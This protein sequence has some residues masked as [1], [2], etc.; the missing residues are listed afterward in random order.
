MFVD[1]VRITVR[2]GKGGNGCISFRREKYVPRGGPNGGNGGN[3][4][5]V[6][7]FSDPNANT[8]LTFRYRKN[9]EAARGRHGQGSLKD[10]KSGHDLRIA[11]PVGTMVFADD[12]EHLLGDLQSPAQEL[13]VARGGRGGRG[14]ACF[15]TST[16][17]APRIAEPGGEGEERHLLLELKLLADVGLVGFPNAG[18]SSLLSRFSAARPKIADYPFTTLTPHLGLV[19]V[20]E[21]K[22]FVMADIPGIIEHAHEGAGLGLRFLK[23]VERTRL[24]LFVIDCS[25]EASREP[26]EAFRILREELRQFNTEMPARPSAVALNKIDLLNPADKKNIVRGYQDSFDV[27]AVP[28]SAVTGEGLEELK[29]VLLRL[30]WPGGEVS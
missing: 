18:K 15:A 11:V 25:P 3:G 30:L 27:P 21:F 23:H 28:V 19:S 29:T 12:K 10:G 17:Q 1:E 4:G 22:G 9:F 26:V 13:I 6:I 14:N 7:I 16:R 20:D 24:L 5:D 8:L 2:G